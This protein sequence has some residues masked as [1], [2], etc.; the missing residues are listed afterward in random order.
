VSAPVLCAVGVVIIF[1]IEFFRTHEILVFVQ[2]L[3]N[4]CFQDGL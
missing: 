4:K 3:W 1:Y 2:W